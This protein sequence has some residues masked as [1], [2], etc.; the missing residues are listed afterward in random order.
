MLVHEVR[1]VGQPHKKAYS[2]EEMI[3]AVL[4]HLKEYN[5]KTVSKI[6]LYSPNLINNTFGWFVGD[7]GCY[8]CDSSEHPYIAKVWRNFNGADVRICNQRVCPYC[9]FVD[10]RND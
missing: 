8:K 3:D 2:A 4:K 5:C 1:F 9:L 10:A 6:Q 7:C